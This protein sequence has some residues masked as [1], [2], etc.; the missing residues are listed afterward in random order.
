[1]NGLLEILIIAVLILFNAVFV[2]AE[3]ALADTLGTF[4][5]YMMTPPLTESALIVSLGEGLLSSARHDHSGDAIIAALM[6]TFFYGMMA[7]ILARRVRT[8]FA[9]VTGR[10]G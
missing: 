6:G 5:L 8:R 4:H 3:T 1:M 2:A 10:K 9:K 7:F